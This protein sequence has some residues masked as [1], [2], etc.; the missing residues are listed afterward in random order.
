VSASPYP[1][2]RARRDPLV[3]AAR[4]ATV[5]SFTLFLH[6]EAP[7]GIMNGAITIALQQ[8]KKG[9]QASQE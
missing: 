9:I 1:Q 4:G 8:K 6:F 7:F 3:N 5:N 2:T